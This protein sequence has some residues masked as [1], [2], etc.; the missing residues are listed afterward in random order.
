MPQL[1]LATTSSGARPI[2]L[3]ATAERVTGKVP[4]KL[5]PSTPQPD[6]EL[7]STVCTEWHCLQCGLFQFFIPGIYSPKFIN[8]PLYLNSCQRTGIVC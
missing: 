5:V 3:S 2:A 8:L 1:Q 7:G 4:T 6:E